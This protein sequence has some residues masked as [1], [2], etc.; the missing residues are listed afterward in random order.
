MDDEHH[1][2]VGIDKNVT[3]NEQY[4]EALVVELFTYFYPIGLEELLKI[5]KILI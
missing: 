3:F 2:A 5:L 4:N 1:F